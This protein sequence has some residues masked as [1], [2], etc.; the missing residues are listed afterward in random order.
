MLTEREKAL[1]L[2]AR[3]GFLQPSAIWNLKYFAN[4]SPVQA[5]KYWSELISPFLNEV[6]D[7]T[8]D[9]Y[10]SH[11]FN[12]DGEVLTFE[13]VVNDKTLKAID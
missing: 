1:I 9:P 10:P 11:M 5:M 12:T 8:G 6:R 7:C 4:C 13:E 2:I 3:F